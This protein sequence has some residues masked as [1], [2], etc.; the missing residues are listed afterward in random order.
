MR[1]I[2]KDNKLVI[3]TEPKTI[4]FDL[5]EDVVNNLKNEIGFIVFS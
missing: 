1:V 3:I 5:T 4:Y 2:I